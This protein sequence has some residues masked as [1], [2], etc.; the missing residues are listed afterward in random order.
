MPTIV[1]YKDENGKIMT[2]HIPQLIRSP[3]EAALFLSSHW[4]AYIRSLN[5]QAAVD[6][7]LK[8]NQGIPKVIQIV[9]RATT[10]LQFQKLASQYHNTVDFG[11]IEETGFADHLYQVHVS[12]LWVVYRIAPSDD[13]RVYSAIRDVRVDLG[14]WALPTMV[15]L[16]RYNFRTLCG[17]SCL[18]RVGEPEAALVRRLCSFNMSTFWVHGGAAA[19]SSLGAAEGDW[20]LLRPADNRFARLPKV[21]GDEV[22]GL[23]QRIG[24]KMSERPL[25]EGFA[26]DWQV[27]LAVQHGVAVVKAWIHRIDFFVIDLTLTASFV[28]YRAYQWIRQKKE[29]MRRQSREP[30]AEKQLKQEQQQPEEPAKEEHEDEDSLE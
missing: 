13:Y 4:D 10:A 8:A 6:A 18:V 27:G 21:P 24:Q 1:Y 29:E 12:P 11:I 26:L 15:E 5:S 23:A 16:H 25:P 3:A 22:N 9:R 28:G 20:L 2:D 7:F 19:A 17:S 30:P 14:R